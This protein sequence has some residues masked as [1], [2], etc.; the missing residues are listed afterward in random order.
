MLPAVAV[1]PKYDR[2]IRLIELA[3][4]FTAPLWVYELFYAW[5]RDES[6]TR[7]FLIPLIVVITGVLV[8]RVSRNDPFLRRAMPVALMFKLSAVAGYLYMS[9][10]FYNFMADVF[11]Y[12]GEGA[13]IANDL[14]LGGHWRWLTPSWGANAIIMAS[15][16]LFTVTGASL[17]VGCVVFAM[18]SFWGQ[19]LFYRTFR[20]GFP[21]GDHE[22]AGMLFFFMPSLAFWTATI[23]KD[24]LMFTGIALAVY[25]FV[26]VNRTMA[27]GGMLLMGS[28]LGVV[29]VVR[30]HMGA[31][32]GMAILVP[33]LIGK[34]LKGIA[35]M[36]GKLFSAPLVIVG[37]YYLAS[38]AQTF[39]NMEDV[40]QGG[41]V[42]ARV[43]RNS[44]IGGSA[45]GG[46]SG[47]S[48]LLEAPLLLFRPF[49]WEA[50]ST[51]SAIAAMEA[52]MILLLVIWSRRSFRA[53]LKEWRRNSLVLLI[54]LYGVEFSLVFA[55][56][57]R[58]F[59]LLTRQRV[60]LLPL[61][62][63][64]FCVPVGAALKVRARAPAR[65]PMARLLRQ[66]QFLAPP[67]GRRRRTMRAPG[68]R[69]G[70]ES[71]DGVS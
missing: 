17:M 5:E 49:P 18:I 38:R 14:A 32:L 6:W 55:A 13:R 26:R 57:I 66:E 51:Q 36:A 42:L 46:G 40:S 69:P 58:N 16:A 33:F 10:D 61:A 63:M 25:G 3:C 1:S 30:P 7:F 48:A 62:L 54:L 43:G 4:L 41:S 67:Q 9:I 39:L 37:T 15:G 56:A 24:A 65:F 64:L 23:G 11:H 22:F 34:N 47:V 44:A 31:M 60:M 68:P 20:L 12:Y 71:P 53:K 59:G 28:G 50:R 52:F 2:V 29:T 35:G 45:I 27:P 19:Y 70:D 21:E 8:V